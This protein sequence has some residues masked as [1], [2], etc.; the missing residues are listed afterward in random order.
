[1]NIPTVVFVAVLPNAA[2]Q[3]FLSGLAT[4]YGAV[5]SVGMLQRFVQVYSKLLFRTARSR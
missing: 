3:I 4:R 5:R 1:M 2:P